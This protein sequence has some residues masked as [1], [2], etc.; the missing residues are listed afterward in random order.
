MWQMHCFSWQHMVKYPQNIWHRPTPVR[1]WGEVY[2]SAQK[3]NLIMSNKI[4]FCIQYDAIELINLYKRCPLQNALEGTSIR[5]LLDDS[6]GSERTSRWQW[7]VSVI[8]HHWQPDWMGHK[9]WRIYICLS[10]KYCNTSNRTPGTLFI[11]L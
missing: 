11:S 10:L 8:C 2:P 4:N 1:N 9:N 3:V 5:P 7:G 6:G